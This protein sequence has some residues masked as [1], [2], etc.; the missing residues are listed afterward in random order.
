MPDK[1]DEVKKEEGKTPLTD[2]ELL[3]MTKKVIASGEEEVLT[4]EEV[5]AIFGDD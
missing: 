3:T 5:S 1:H 4:A 2:E